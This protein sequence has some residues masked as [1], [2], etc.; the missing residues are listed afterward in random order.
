M[1][2]YE[3]RKATSD[4]DPQCITIWKASGKTL[5]FQHDNDSKQ[6]C[7]CN[8]RKENHMVENYKSWTGLPKALKQCESV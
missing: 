5:T 7:Q 6:K 2:N 4:F 1:F 8:K 3:G